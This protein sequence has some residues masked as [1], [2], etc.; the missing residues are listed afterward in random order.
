MLPLPPGFS[1]VVRARTE[2]FKGKPAKWRMAEP[3]LLIVIFVTLGMILPLFFPCTPTQVSPALTPTS[4]LAACWVR[5]PVP[6]GAA[7]SQRGSLALH[8]HSQLRRRR[9]LCAVCD[10]PGGDQA[11]LPR[12]HL[13]PDQVSAAAGWPTIRCHCAHALPHLTPAV[14]STLPPTPNPRRSAGGL[15]KKARSSTPAAG[16][17]RTRVS[18]GDGQ[19]PSAACSGRW[20][21]Q[22]GA[23]SLPAAP[24][25]LPC[26]CLAACPAPSA[27]HLPA[28][29]RSLLSCRLP[30]LPATRPFAPPTAPRRN[31]S[32]VGP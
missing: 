10:H 30:C 8:T 26:A 11:S 9:R 15:W 12:R 21:Q 14:P 6:A 16:R 19:Q 24:K 32:G 29:P 27:A 17:Q 31:P 28:P 4:S 7:P 22:L 13:G 23:S 20:A 2:F 1:Q 5:R 3:C 25:R 18:G